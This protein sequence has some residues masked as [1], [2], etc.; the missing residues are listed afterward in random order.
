MSG[1]GMSQG[2]GPLLLWPWSVLC[3]GWVCRDL[4]PQLFLC[5]GHIGLLFVRP[6]FADF[7][8]IPATSGF[9]PLL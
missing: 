9:Q 2:V 6:A 1:E 7:F 5:R 8:G 4:G 3:A